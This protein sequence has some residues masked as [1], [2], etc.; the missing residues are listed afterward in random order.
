MSFSVIIPARLESTRLSNKVLQKINDKEILI[1]VLEQVTKSNANR[2]LIATDSDEIARVVSN[3]KGEVVMT[4]DCDSGSERVAQ[5][6]EKL[7]LEGVIINVQGDVPEVPPEIINNLANKVVNSNIQVATAVAKISYE[8]ACS[9][10]TVKV[11]FDQNDN[12]LYFSRSI[13]P[14]AKEKNSDYYGHIGIYAF[15]PN[16]VIEA[17]TLEKSK[18]ATAESLEQ[19]TWLEA[20]WKIGIIQTTEFINGID[21]EQDLLAAKARFK[22]ND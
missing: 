11:V 18:L 6:V 1:H 22:K 5:A 21:T 19:L 8:Q 9:N 4:T 20:G 2:V 15:A 3:T 14:Y 13:I 10:D 7:N 17:L 12:A 16:K